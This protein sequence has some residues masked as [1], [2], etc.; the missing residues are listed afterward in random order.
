[1][2]VLASGKLKWLFPCVN[3]FTA[4]GL[5]GF[6]IYEMGCKTAPRTVTA[7]E[8][9]RLPINSS[10]SPRYRKQLAEELCSM[11]PPGETNEP[12]WLFWLRPLAYLVYGV[13][14]KADPHALNFDQRI[15]S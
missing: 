12:S 3:T 7:Y 15:P 9:Q 8:S 13:T 5:Y 10:Y 14:F 2:T 6:L 4:I 11:N 1:M